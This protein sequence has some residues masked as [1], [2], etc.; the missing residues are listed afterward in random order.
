MSFFIN[1]ARIFTFTLNVFKGVFRSP[2]EWRELLNQCY[3]VGN[4]TVW[5]L[6][7]ISMI[8]GFLFAKG[9]GP[10]LERLGEESLLPG[11]V[12]IGIIRS[13]G[14]LITALI[15]AGKLGS[16]IGADLSSLNISGPT[17]GI[18]ASGTN[19]FQY[20]VV[21]R[22]LAVAFMLPLLVIYSDLICLLGGFL[23]VNFSSETNISLYFLE[24]FDNVTITDL[25]ITLIKPF[26]FGLGIGLVSTYSGYY[27]SRDSSGIGKAATASVVYSMVTMFILDFISIQIV[28]FINQFNE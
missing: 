21:T 23:F 11:I 17:D 16:V 7:F 18:D 5:I 24:I 27:S 28:Q 3:W 9:S 10:A 12:G 2:F 13:F 26:F 20:V 25:V 8:T 19:S 22:V 1:L 6:G 15:S 14:P 4:K